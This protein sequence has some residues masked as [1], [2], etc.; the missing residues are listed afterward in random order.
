MSNIQL[1]RNAPVSREFEVVV[2]SKNELIAV[3]HFGLHIN[4]L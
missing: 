1:Y 4:P 2:E 3:R